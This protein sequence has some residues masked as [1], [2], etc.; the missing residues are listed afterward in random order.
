MLVTPAALASRRPNSRNPPQQSTAR[1]EPVGPTRPASSIAVSPK[2]QPAST[3]LSPL[4]TASAGKIL[5]LWSDNP[6]TRMWRHRTN[7]GTRT[8]FQKSTYWLLG[9]MAASM[10]LMA[11]SQQSHRPGRTSTRQGPDFACDLAY[12]GFV[13]F[14]IVWKM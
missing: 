8:A 14:D 5:A 6:P 4:R 13:G 12:K 1:T 9:V 3:T 2:P 7:L 11:G 10:L